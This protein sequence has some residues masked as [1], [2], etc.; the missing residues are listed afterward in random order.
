MAIYRAVGHASEPSRRMLRASR[1][2]VD[3]PP[4]IAAT[5]ESHA[6]RIF[7]RQG[8]LHRVRYNAIVADTIIDE[9]MSYVR[10]SKD[11]ARH[12]AS[13]AG[14]LG[15]GLPEV[16]QRFYDEILKHR[17]ARRVFTGGQAQ[18]DRLRG[19]FLNWLKTLFSGTYD[20]AYFR[21]RES[22][23]HVHVRVGL[24]QHY[25]PA[26]MEVV[27]QELQR[28]IRA[29]SFPDV[30]KKLSA[31]HKLLA[32]E[33]AVMLESYKERY[34]DQVRDVERKVLHERLSRAEHLAEIGQLAASLAHEIK[35][36]LA[37]ISGAIQVIR[38]STAGDN[39]HRPILEEILRQITRLDRTVKDLLDYA[40]PTKPQ[41]RVC[42]I[43][44]IA[45]RVARL[46]GRETAFTRI[47]L[48]VVC[49]G[50]P[51]IE[52]DEQQIA[53]LMMNLLLNAAHASPDGGRVRIRAV[54]ES[55]EVLISVEDEGHG[56]DED[57][58]RRAFEPF[59]TTKARG[60][61]LGLSICQRIVESLRGTIEIS[62]ERNRGTTVTIRMP[63]RQAK[64]PARAGG[65]SRTPFE[66]DSIELGGDA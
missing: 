37:G 20:E 18:L 24:P 46:L 51:S 60:T 48:E 34:T 66:A 2:D 50:A 8:V 9:L 61:G 41:I 35:N 14:P 4:A 6:G 23:G 38:D 55:D 19:H 42:E 53:Q 56:M 3:L 39:P 31:L 36:P 32:L 57:V 62:S 12:L 49:D 29:A 52:A 13:L 27:W 54:G 21:Q 44:T 25:M 58:C 10:F 7:P 47:R 65:L 17:D 22:I 15:P 26:A 40:R 5:A 63:I 59:F 45:Q 16:V 30:E 33:T 43:S 11:D 28:L 1:H 64:A